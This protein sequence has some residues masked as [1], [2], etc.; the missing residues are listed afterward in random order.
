MNNTPERTEDPSAGW[1]VC[2]TWSTAM[3]H[4]YIHHSQHKI[5]IYIFKESGLKSVSSKKLFATNRLRLLFQV[6]KI[7]FC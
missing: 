6:S 2:N 1:T 3:V 5:A 7:L 4:I